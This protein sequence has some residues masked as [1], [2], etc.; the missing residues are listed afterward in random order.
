MLSNLGVALSVR[1]ERT[2]VRADLDEAIAADRLA[3]AALTDSQPVIAPI[4]SNLSGLLVR[5]SPAR[6]TRRW[7]ALWTLQ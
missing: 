6:R 7:K 3:V 5:R 2:G 4:L 1:F